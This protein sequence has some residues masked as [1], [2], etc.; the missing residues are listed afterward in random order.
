MKSLLEFWKSFKG[1]KRPKKEK[2]GQFVSQVSAEQQVDQ[3]SVK[4]IQASPKPP[5]RLFKKKSQKVYIQVGLDFGTS[6]TKVVFS[7]LGKRLFRAIDFGH[8]LPNFPSYCLPS[9]CSIDSHGNLMFGADAADYL[10]DQSWD[11]G[12]RRFKVVVA[13]K[14]DAQFT[15]KL[16][17]KSYYGYLRTNALFIEPEY[18][19]AFYL[20][21]VMEKTRSI[22]QHLPEYR[23]ADIDYTYNVCV[24]IDQVENSKVYEAFNSI[25]LLAEKIDK[26]WQNSVIKMNAV[27]ELISLEAGSDTSKKVYA[28]PE[29]VASFASYLVSLNKREGRHAVIDFGSGT[30]DLSICNL[31]MPV[32]KGPR[33]YWYAARNIPR[34]TVNVERAIACLLHENSCSDRLTSKDIDKCLRNIAFPQERGYALNVKP[35][36]RKAVFDELT[37]LRD[38]KEYKLTWGAAYKHLVRDKDWENVEILTCGGGS[39]FPQVE[40]VFRRPWWPQI[41]S[42]Y[43]VNKLPVPD[44]FDPGPSKAPFERMSVAYGLAIP[45]PQLEK[46]KLPGHSPDHT[47]PEPPEYSPDSDDLYPK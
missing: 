6:S 31:T 47:P 5:S 39:N 37:D 8:D 45:L 1:T 40:E 36:Y 19:S 28:V 3:D 34:G 12:L 22:I 33:C 14:H 24:P 10:Q 44:N 38:S 21:H 43:P 11:T 18:L 20:S 23:H 29:A 2:D 9:V 46:F 26:S 32:N 27:N 7:Q 25:F 15:D 42:H 30:T 4:P 16:T 13:G 35:E 41:K 17:S